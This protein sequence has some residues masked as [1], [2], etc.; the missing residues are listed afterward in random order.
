MHMIIHAAHCK[1]EHVMVLANPRDVRPESSLNCL[2]DGFF[3]AFRTEHKMDMILRVRMR[4]ECRTS[5]ARSQHIQPRA[6]ATGLGC[7]ALRALRL[8]SANRDFAPA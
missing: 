3:A 1:R 7:C 6:S 8:S 4:H 5:G 2:R